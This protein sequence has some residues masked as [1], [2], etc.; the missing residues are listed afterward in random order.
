MNIIAAS[1]PVF[2]VDGG[3]TM[4]VVFEETGPD[5]ILFTAHAYDIEPHGRELFNRAQAGEFGQIEAYT[6]P[7]VPEPIVVDAISDRQFALQ[8]RDLGFLTQ[9]EAVAF[10]S[11]GSLPAL[12]VAFIASLP[13][14]SAR[15][16]AEITIAGATVLERRHPLTIALGEMMRGE[17]PID[18]FLDDFFRTACA[19]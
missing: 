18:V 15:D 7:P 5:P 2:D 14:Q 1:N 11:S 9:A 3:I 12:L 19:R 16:D 4:Q 13:T 6:A 10:V 8:A 17:V